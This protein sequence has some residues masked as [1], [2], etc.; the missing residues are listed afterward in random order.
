MSN[1]L[2]KDN[3]EMYLKELAKEFRRLNGKT[4]QAEIIIV[5]GAS[6]ILNYGFRDSTTDIDAAMRASSAMNDA[7]RIITDKYGLDSGW[8]NEDFLK[9]SSF[10]QE[11]YRCAK[12]YRTYSNILRI[13]TV[14]GKYLVAMKLMSFRD[15]RNDISDVIGIIDTHRKRNEDISLPDIKFA[16][17][18]LYGSYEALPQLAREFL[19]DLF[20][21]DDLDELYNK[22]ISE[23]E[24]NKDILINFDKKYDGALTQDNVHDILQSLKER[25]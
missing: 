5:G 16:A 17:K 25:R 19:E 11:L 14:S 12:Y 21:R 13:Y 18:E 22:R 3:I 6:I 9:T 20:S 15:Y 7:I 10:S 2:Y 23:E 8:I 24:D 4:M 1:K